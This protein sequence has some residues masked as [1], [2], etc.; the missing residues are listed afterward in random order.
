PDN[1]FKDFMHEA[2][3]GLI[4]N[5]LPDGLKST[6]KYKTRWRI[7]RENGELVLEISDRASDKVV[8]VF[9]QQEIEKKLTEK[10]RKGSESSGSLIDKTA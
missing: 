10:G 2:G 9:T 7:N 3:F 1:G 5:I 6:R 8:M 4:A